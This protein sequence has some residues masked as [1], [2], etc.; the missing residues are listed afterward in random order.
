MPL[1]I[2]LFFIVWI[3]IGF[4]IFTQLRLGLNNK[5]FRIYKFKTLYDQGSSELER[6]S[7]IGNF[8]R[9]FGL[10]ELPQLFNILKNDMSFIGPRPLLAEYLNKY[11]KEEIKR[12][13]VKPGITGL[14]Q[15]SGNNSLS[16]NE[17][18]NYDLI[19]IQN[20]SFVNDLKIYFKTII[21]L[22]CGKKK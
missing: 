18:M 13:N 17:K 6:Q 5:L 19:Y 10:D 16:F 4:P 3:I 21:I 7:K 14:S 2:L 1:M 22:F 12:H 9:Q 11:S 20:L 8:L 15:V